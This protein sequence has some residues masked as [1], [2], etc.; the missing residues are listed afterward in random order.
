MFSSIRHELVVISDVHLRTTDD[1]RGRLLLHLLSRLETANVRYLV[2]LGDIFDFCVGYSPYFQ[3]KFAPIGHALTR[4]AQLG[5]KVYFV[6]GNHEFLMR[7][8]PW[9]SIEFVTE[10]DLK[11]K[12][13][14]GNSLVLAHGDLLRAPW[15][16]RLYTQFIRSRLVR[17]IALR[18]P[19]AILDRCALS[20]SARSRKR[21]YS[22]QIAHKAIVASIT[23]WAKTRGADFGVVGHF[24]VPY[25]VKDG[26]G[27]PRIFCLDSWDKPNCLTYDAGRFYRIYLKETRLNLVEL[28]S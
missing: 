19:Q 13:S 11:L 23:Q 14:N 24:H 2:L 4:I 18:M 7:S 22:R 1:E 9:P 28:P 15:H 26:T 6:E 20:I 8:L 21:G 17:L 3:E 10:L 12:L 16:Y 5:V 25:D 27:K